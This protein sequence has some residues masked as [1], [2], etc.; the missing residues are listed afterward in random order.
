LDPQDENTPEDGIVDTGPM[1][2]LVRPAGR[3]GSHSVDIPP[4]VH[5]NQQGHYDD[6][7]RLVFTTS[8]HEAGVQV[9]NNFQQFGLPSIGPVWCQQESYKLCFG[10]GFGGRCKSDLVP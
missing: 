3:M 7:G 10:G 2:M 1:N 5:W 8:K 6:G 4:N 9:S